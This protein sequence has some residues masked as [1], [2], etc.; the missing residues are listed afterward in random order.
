MLLAAACRDPLS[1]GEI[2][3]GDLLLPERHQPAGWV[4]R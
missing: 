2:L 1:E 4:V 3:A